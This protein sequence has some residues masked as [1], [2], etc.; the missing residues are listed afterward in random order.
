MGARTPSN[1]SAGLSRRDTL[2]MLSGAAAAAALG[3]PESN[4]PAPMR[5][6]A[7]PSSGE[8]LPVVGIGTWQTFDVGASASERRPLEEV[9]RVFAER[10][11][12]VVD[13][14][15]MYGRSEGVVGDL[16]RGLGVTDS[17][18]L[19]TK[20][21]TTGRQAG[22][23]Q[24]E[25]SLSLLGG[26][27]LDL[28]QVHNLVDVA[29]HLRTLAAWKEAG[30]VRYVGITHYSAGAYP[31]VERVLRSE[32][33]DFLQINYSLA[34]PQAELRLLPLAAERGVAVIA[35]RPFGGGEALRRASGRPLPTWAAELGCASW[36][37]FFLKW[38]LGHPAVTCVIPG[39]GKVRHLEDNLAAAEG[40]VPDATQRRRM[41]EAAAAVL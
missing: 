33:L 13:S 30:R 32:R 17:L 19:A 2:R 14:S 27:R 37:Q 31:E 6:R 28:E 38:I 41:A 3:A 22:V 35:N 7:I 4:R 8:A 29:T 34:E 15:P 36:A 12:R 39:T 5:A 20:V 16:A 23:D 18:F 9:L 26:R 25:R 10:G 21:W 40:P 1:S 11:G 24:M